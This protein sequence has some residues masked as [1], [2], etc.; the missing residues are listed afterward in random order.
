MIKTAEW[1]HAESASDRAQAQLTADAPDMKQHSPAHKIGL[2]LRSICN[3]I[4]LPI[5]A[6]TK[7]AF[8]FAK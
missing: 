4:P 3:R 7:H 1:T 6:H 2:S 8:P 5:G